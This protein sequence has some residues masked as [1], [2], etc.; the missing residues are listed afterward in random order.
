MTATLSSSAFFDFTH[1]Q[2]IAFSDSV[3]NASMSDTE[4]AV[5]QLLSHY[6]KTGDFLKAYIK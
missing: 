2:V 1:P 5:A 6:E 4:K 3:V